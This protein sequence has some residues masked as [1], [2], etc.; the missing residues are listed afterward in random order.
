MREDNI[1]INEREPNMSTTSEELDDLRDEITSGL[2]DAN[3]QP[4]IEE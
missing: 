3:E 2:T 4:Q 1:G